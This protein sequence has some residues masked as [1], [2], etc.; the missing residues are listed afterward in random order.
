[1]RFLR[2][3]STWRLGLGLLGYICKSGKPV[4]I[5]L[6]TEE[7][8]MNT[9]A[10]ISIQDQLGYVNSSKIVRAQYPTTTT[11]LSPE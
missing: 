4:I 7:I 9:M 6:A 2:F 3:P 5:I 10:I 11:Q 1:M 8:V